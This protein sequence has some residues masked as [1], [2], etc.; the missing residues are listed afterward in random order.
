M[1]HE[2]DGGCYSSS[3]SPAAQNATSS[4]SSSPIDFAGSSSSSG[5]T[6]AGTAG[7]AATTGAGSRRCRTIAG[8]HR[9]LRRY[10]LLWCSCSLLRRR[11]PHPHGGAHLPRNSAVV[12]NS[13]MILPDQPSTASPKTPRIVLLLVC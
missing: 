8:R 11:D 1:R 13:T 9:L 7:A 5:S 4:S 12:G 2:G 6:A 10:M 3:P